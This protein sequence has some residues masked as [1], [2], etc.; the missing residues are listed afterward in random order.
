MILFQVSLT[1]IKKQLLRDDHL[2]ENVLA[3][4]LYNTNSYWIKWLLS[5]IVESQGKKDC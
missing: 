4:L 5:G 3:E 2:A 1:E